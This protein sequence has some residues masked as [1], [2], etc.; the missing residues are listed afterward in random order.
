M[1]TQLDSS[2]NLETSRRMAQDSSSMHTITV[3]TMV[4]LPGTFTAVSLLH[5]WIY[6]GTNIESD[7]LL[8]CGLHS[9]RLR[10]D[11]VH[12]LALAISRCGHIFDCGC[13]DDVVL[14]SKS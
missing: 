11:A 3:V 4:F 5:T 2:T 13:C 9:N 14:P 6:Q 8:H 12:G 7:S 10:E 1:V